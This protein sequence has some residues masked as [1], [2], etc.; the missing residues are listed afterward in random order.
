M[1]ISKQDKILLEYLVER[2]GADGVINELNIPKKLLPAIVAGG[3]SIGGLGGTHL[4]NNLV[5][6]HNDSVENPEETVED[7][8]SN[9]YNMSDEDYALFIEKAEAVKD[10]IDRVLAFRGMSSDDI[11]FDIEN[12]VY[13]CYKYNFDLPLALA[14]LR[15]ESH[16]G[17]TPRA[18]KTNS[19][20]SI[21]AYD[22]GKNGTWYES[23]DDSIEPYILIMKRDFL[24]NGKRTVDAILNPGGFYRLFGAR[25]ARYARD[26]DYEDTLR[27]VRRGIIKRSPVLAQEYN[28]Y[29]LNEI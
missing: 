24:Q 1:N 8:P 13:N 22:S 7:T 25:K 27:S 17:T 18:K 12:L 6:K 14:Q 21:G 2:Y 3:I 29:N 16:F 28:S 23:M 20:F 5:N 15:C 9:P 10:E 4:V 19:M 26:P 11:D